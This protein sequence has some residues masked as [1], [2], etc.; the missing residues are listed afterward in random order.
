[1]KEEVHR[2]T[3]AEVKKKKFVYHFAVS[4]LYQCQT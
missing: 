2:G 1:M 3:F 4:V